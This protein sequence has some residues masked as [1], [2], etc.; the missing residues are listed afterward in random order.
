VLALALAAACHSHPAPPAGAA[1]PLDR[2]QCT[3][4]ASSAQLGCV[5]DPKAVVGWCVAVGRLA[6]VA[7]CAPQ[8]RR[9]FECAARVAA[10]CNGAPCC[11]TSL[12]CADANTAL[13][14]CARGYCGGHGANP[15]C[16]WT[17]QSVDT[18]I[19]LLSPPSSAQL[20]D[21]ARAAAAVAAITAPPSSV[22]PTELAGDLDLDLEA[23]IRKI[24]DTHYEVSGA[25]VEKIL[26]NPMAVAKG[27]RVVPAVKNGKPD[28][29]KLYA[30]RYNSPWARLGLLNG[31]TVQA[32]NGFR[33]ESADKALEVY[34]ALRE[35]KSLDIELERR[36][37]PVRLYITIKR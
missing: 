14:H 21:V 23:G 10:R 22:D 34:T 3:T 2:A 4:L 37:A 32:I 1:P 7:A 5:A 6:E 15:D 36:G 27:A 29:F 9:A 18:A 25:A 12:D 11:A 31:D 19:S 24:D 28:G 13:D 26:Q 17:G 16:S 8:A 33:L 35:A 30:I 20:A